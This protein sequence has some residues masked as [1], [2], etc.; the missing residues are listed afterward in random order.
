MSQEHTITASA[1]ADHFQMSE[2]V[3]VLGAMPSRIEPKV[4][5]SKTQAGRG[6]FAFNF[7]GVAAWNLDER[8]NAKLISDIKNLKSS[9]RAGPQGF[10]EFNIYEDA[11]ETPRVEFNRVVVD[12]LTPDRTELIALTL[13]QS[14]AMEVY[15]RDLD[16]MYL[17]VSKLVETL[18]TDGKVSARARKLNRIIGETVL[19]RNE[20]LGVLHLLDRPDLI[21]EDRIMDGLYGDLR[22]VFDLDERF[23]ALERKL[24]A[25]QDSLEIILDTVRDRRLF[26]VEISILALIAFEVAIYLVDLSLLK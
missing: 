13:S 10:E 25:I 14:A 26:L 8:E 3:K 17:A 2:I 6:F 24:Q 16:R 7:G 4:A 1:F 20:V 21:W 12:Q 19:V 23:Q 11:K 18:K 9:D 22:A 15:E 5:V